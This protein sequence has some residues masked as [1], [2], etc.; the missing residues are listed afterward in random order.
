M[1][2]KNNSQ[3]G[4]MN[5]NMEKNTP[6]SADKASSQ[7]LWKSVLVGGVPGILI[8]AAGT[9]GID[10]ALAK[11]PGD[12]DATS[13]EI[14]IREAHSVNDGMNF[15]EAF[16]AARAEVGPGGAFAWHGGVY[17]TFST[18]DAE[19]IEMSA[20]ER[21]AHSQAILSQVHAHP[22]FSSY[23]EPIIEPSPEEPAGTDQPVASEFPV[24][25]DQSS[26]TAQPEMRIIDIE[27]VE[28]E[29]GEVVQV[30]YG[31][32]DDHMMTLVDTDGDHILDTV[33]V[34]QNDNLQIDTGEQYQ[35]MDPGVSTGGDY[36]NDADI[37][38]LL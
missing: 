33:V 14:E 17:G 6:R 13:P 29:D 25:Q 9:Y 24:E 4:T 30:G 32:C 11:A 31:I 37:S 27:P 7:S 15:N 3:T 2:T 8:G 12:E 34:D 26:E 28:L 18:E 10:S 16:A 1:E 36:S 20:E 19:W 21:Q 35:F 5:V 38:N 22:Y 23:D